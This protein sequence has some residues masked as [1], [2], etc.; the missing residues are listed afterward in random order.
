M[1]K[2]RSRD[3]AGW[4]AV[5]VAAALGAGC[6]GS[7]TGLPPGDYTPRD[8]SQEVALP[9]ADMSAARRDALQRT[10]V[11]QEPPVPVAQ[12]DLGR[13]PPGPGALGRDARLLCRFQYRS[14]PGYSPKFHCV[15]LGGDVLKVKYGW[16]SREVRTEVAATRLLAALGFGA[17][18]MYVVERVRCFGCPPYPYEK[19]AW[20]GILRVD[21]REY[22]DFD[23]V[24]IERPMGGA[25]LETVEEKG[26]RWDELALIDPARGGSSRAEVDA[27]R[28]MAVF[29]SNWDTKDANQRL[30]CLPDEDA[31]RPGAPRVPCARPFAYMQ[32]VGTSFGPHS[33]N[34]TTWTSRP[35][36]ADA[37]T[38]TVSMKGLPY[39]GATF[40]DVR[41]SEGG[42]RFLAERLAALSARQIEDLFR[43]ARFPDFPWKHEED[44]D[45]GRW[46][47]GFQDRVRQIADRTP[48]P[49]P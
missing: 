14:S 18:R 43:A 20:L 45:L 23:F 27:F 40:R 8:R 39:D 26:W 17:D 44:G 21:Y 2:S 12:A 34:L 37:A 9:A 3:V 28:L 35:V 47:V 7:G 1:E 32:D 33:M 16:N 13:E 6:A 15:Q 38:C 19:L 25:A 29:L 11:W 41:I 24:S 22:R 5:A 30:V 10:R 31:A 4:G 48:C 36:W 42:R 49:E 46:V